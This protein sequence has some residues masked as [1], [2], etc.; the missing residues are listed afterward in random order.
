MYVFKLIWDFCPSHFPACDGGDGRMGHC[1]CWFRL[2]T[3]GSVG[4][5]RMRTDVLRGW[6]TRESNGGRWTPGVPNTRLSV[7]WD[8]RKTEDGLTVV[9]HVV[10]NVPLSKISTKVSLI[11]LVVM[12]DDP[13]PK[14][15]CS[16][17]FCLTVSDCVPCLMLT[18]RG[19]ANFNRAR[20]V[21][22]PC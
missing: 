22:R 5:R 9:F 16:P 13:N 3:S 18:Q 14:N 17:V 2:R 11:V 21:S 20:I 12:V 19:L 10:T 1:E 8:C 6:K 7:R 15:V 4:L